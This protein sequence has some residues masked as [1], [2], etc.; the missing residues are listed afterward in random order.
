MPDRDWTTT[1][2]RRFA[3]LLY[4]RFW[5]TQSGDSAEVYTRLRDFDE[6]G[7]LLEKIRQ[8]WHAVGAEALD[9]IEAERERHAVREADLR[10]RIDNEVGLRRAQNFFW[11]V[12]TVLAIAAALFA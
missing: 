5:E 7:R 2:Q 12:F 6:G 9:C 11:G 4:Q 1:K 8:A 10:A 3:R